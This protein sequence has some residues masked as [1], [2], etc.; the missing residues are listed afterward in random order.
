MRAEG[1]AIT[2]ETGVVKGDVHAVDLLV[3]GRLEGNVHAQ[4]LHLQASAQIHGNIKAETLQV[5]PGARYP[6]SVIM[7]DADTAPA[8]LPFS[9]SAPEADNA[10]SRPTKA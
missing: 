5:Y 7:R 9:P 8:V 2:G 1:R 10:A 4:R 3:L 6:G